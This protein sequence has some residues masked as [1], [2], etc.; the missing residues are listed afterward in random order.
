[1]LLKKLQPWLIGYVLFCA[2]CFI[3]YQKGVADTVENNLTANIK[4]LQASI[5]DLD[6]ETKKAGNLNLQLSQLFSARKKADA[7]YTKVFTN[8]LSTTKHLRINCV[9]DNNIMQQLNE[10]ADRADAAATSGITSALRTGDPP[11]R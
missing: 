2:A 9:F 5:S 4:S 6:E 3:S 8:A 1:M 10:S 7:E 11:N